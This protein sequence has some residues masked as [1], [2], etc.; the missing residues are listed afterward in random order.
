MEIHSDVSHCYR[1]VKY[2][3]ILHLIPW[4]HATRATGVSGYISI[5]LLH[6]VNSWKYLTIFNLSGAHKS[7]GIE[8]SQ[9]RT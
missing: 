5:S 4:G 1:N 2:A 9:F 8:V 7:L 6:I 3:D